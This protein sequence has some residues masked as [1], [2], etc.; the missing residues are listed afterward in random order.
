MI[1]KYI[2]EGSVTYI[3]N[4]Y[5][6]RR[7]YK[8]LG[9]IK[10]ISLLRD[11]IERAVSH[12]KYYTNPDSTF[13]RKNPSDLETRSIEEAFY[14]DIKR[15]DQNPNKQYLRFG[16][17]D[18]Q[19]NDYYK[20]FGDSRILVIDFDD[21]KN[22]AAKVMKEVS[23][24]L[25]IER[26]FFNDFIS[27]NEKIESLDSFNQINIKKTFSAYNAQVYDFELDQQ[28]EEDLINFFRSDVKR[29]SQRIDKNFI[30]ME[31]YL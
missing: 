23:E 24:F 1:N 11:P 17:Y 20:Y 25:N 2:Y 14:D 31:K 6:A 8:H 28:L 21:L 5:S 15:V 12:Y 30:W 4:E 29:L 10:I 16:L 18:K 22:K 9:K 13:A 26:N 19:L 3:H 7:I 27:C